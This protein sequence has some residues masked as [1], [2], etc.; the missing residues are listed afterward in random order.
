MSIQLKREGGGKMA[1]FIVIAI[2]CIC[3]GAIVYFTIKR[4]KEGKSGCGCGCSHCTSGTC[5]SRES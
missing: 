2:I 1:D 5:H 4:K 3:M